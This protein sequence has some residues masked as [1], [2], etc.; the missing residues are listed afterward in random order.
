MAPTGTAGR[1]VPSQNRMVL[2]LKR[3]FDENTIGEGEARFNFE[4]HMKLALPYTVT[5]RV[6]KG[7][8]AGIEEGLKASFT[9]RVHG[10][11]ISARMHASLTSDTNMDISGG[12]PATQIVDGGVTYTQWA[13]TAVPKTL[14]VHRLMPIL[15][16]VVTSEHIPETSKIAWSDS[17]DV[18]G[19]LN[20]SRV[21]DQF[22]E[23]KLPDLASVLLTAIVSFVVSALVT[24][25]INRRRQKKKQKVR[26]AREL[27]RLA[28]QESTKPDTQGQPPL[29][30]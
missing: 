16:C 4:E 17:F 18:Y 24:Y 21:R 8:I 23:T 26:Y 7:Q 14:G 30:E 13:W 6:T 19:D 1:H 29:G 10:V 25:F 20:W 28:V 27:K 15:M 2:A 5:L 9:K 12:E 22:M 3:A 11:S